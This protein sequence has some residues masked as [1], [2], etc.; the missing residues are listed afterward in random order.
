[1]PQASVAVNVLVCDREH[2]LLVTAPSD[3]VT[4]GVL[5]ASVAVAEPSAALI[6]ADVGLQPRLPFAGIPVAV[7]VGAVIS[8]VHVAVRDAV[9]VLPQASVAVNVLVCEREHPLL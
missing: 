1:L 8:T 7:M 2:P 3:D 4:V 5:Q 9:D 6:A